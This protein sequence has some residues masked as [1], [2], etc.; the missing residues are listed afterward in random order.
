LRI[1]VDLRNSTRPEVEKAQ[2]NLQ[3]LNAVVKELWTGKVPNNVQTDLQETNKLLEQMATDPG[4]HRIDVEQV[5][6]VT[7]HEIVEKGRIKPGAG[8]CR[9][10]QFIIDGVVP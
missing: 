8:D 6:A 10:A 4:L 9:S 3:N 5:L 2:Q 1:R 7:E